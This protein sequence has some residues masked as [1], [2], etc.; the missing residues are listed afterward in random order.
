[1]KGN[2]YGV[3]RFT[4]PNKGMCCCRA[5]GLNCVLQ[6]L[7]IGPYTHDFVNELAEPN[8]NGLRPPD[9]Y[10]TTCN[11]TCYRLYWDGFWNN[12][13]GVVK[14]GGTGSTCYAPANGSISIDEGTYSDIQSH[15]ASD[16]G[17]YWEWGPS[18]GDICTHLPPP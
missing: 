12:W 17:Y 14:A 4:D 1:M 11:A 7:G 2:K 6:V 10:C 13:E 9:Q 8:P 16:C 5:E 18:L 15:I 3:P